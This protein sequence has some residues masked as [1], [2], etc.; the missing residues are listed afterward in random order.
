MQVK[1]EDLERCVVEDDIARTMLQNQNGD[2]LEAV[3]AA[4]K[5]GDPTGAIELLAEDAG[6][7]EFEPN[8]ETIV[9]DTGHETDSG[10]DGRT[11]KRV[12]LS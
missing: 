4:R 2:L 3:E 1:C 5:G 8:L 10:E 9:G 11:K 12:R 6:A 7:V